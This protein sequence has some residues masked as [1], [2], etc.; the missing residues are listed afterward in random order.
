MNPFTTSPSHSAMTVSLYYVAYRIFAGPPLAGEAPILFYRG[1]NPLSTALIK[2]Y[3]KSATE[4]PLSKISNI[5]V[6]TTV[7]LLVFIWAAGFGLGILCLQTTNRI[8]DCKEDRNMSTTTWYITYLYT[9]HI[10]GTHYF[11]WHWKSRP[12]ISRISVQIR[13]LRIVHTKLQLQ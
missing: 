7:K 10:Q 12:R 8:P 2:R 5:H 6:N 1:P 9:G 13:Y 4:C 3:C 11:L